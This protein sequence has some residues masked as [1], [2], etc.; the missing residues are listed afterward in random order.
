M[1]NAKQTLIAA[2]ELIQQ[3]RYEEAQALLLP[4]A[5]HPTAEKWLDKLNEKILTQL[6]QGQPAISSPP[7][8]SLPVSPTPQKAPRSAETEEAMKA[9]KKVFRTIAGAIVVTSL[10]I[11]T[12]MVVFPMISDAIAGTSTY[13]NTVL[14]LEYNNQWEDFTSHSEASCT[15]IVPPCFLWIE[16]HSQNQGIGMAFYTQDLRPLLNSEQQALEN[17]ATFRQQQG[18]INEDVLSIKKTN[19]AG[20]PAYAFEFVLTNPIPEH[21]NLYVIRY[22]VMQPYRV[23]DIYILSETQALYQKNAKKVTKVLDSITFK[24]STPS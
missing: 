13:E 4:I 9:L 18:I 16:Y 23:V 8:A 24:D 3:K 12:R 19:L 7:S 11:F 15:K 14:S 1:Q 20:I 5:N 6:E 17:W 22:S 10:S 2:K 21:P